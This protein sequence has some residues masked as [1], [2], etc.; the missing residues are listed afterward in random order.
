MALKRRSETNK[1][2]HVQVIT[3]VLSTKY[4]TDMSAESG[5]SSC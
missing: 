5:Y 3:D 2:L 1:L 4:L